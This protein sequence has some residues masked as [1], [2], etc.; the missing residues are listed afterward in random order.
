VC[1]TFHVLRPWDMLTGGASEPSMYWNML[2][3]MLRKWYQTE[4]NCTQPTL[5]DITL[6]SITTS[7]K[8]SVPWSCFR[9]HTA[10]TS[11]VLHA[12]PITTSFIIC[13]FLIFLQMKQ[14]LSIQYFPAPNVEVKWFRF[15]EVPGSNLG[16]K[17][18]YPENFVFFSG[19]PSK[20]RGSNLS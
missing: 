19:S 17:T 18:G 2:N 1:V 13:W 11:C 9:T 8:R 12:P 3:V 15:W 5:Y 6:L 14:L 4:T 16:H 20:F 10:Q 7:S